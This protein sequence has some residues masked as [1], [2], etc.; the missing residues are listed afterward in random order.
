MT[1]PSVDPLE[2]REWFER[3]N[4][5]CLAEDPP[6]RVPTVDPP[7]IDVDDGDATD[8]HD[9]ASSIVT[10]LRD[11]LDSSNQATFESAG[12][13]A[14][15]EALPREHRALRDEAFWTWFACVP[16]RELVLARYPAPEPGA[17][18]KNGN[19]KS[20]LRD[21][22]NFL[23]K[24]ARETLPFRLWIRAE[25]SFDPSVRDPYAA[26][27]LGMID[28]WRSHVF[29]PL[30]AHHRPFLRA[31]IAFQFP[32][33]GDGPALNTAQVREMAKELSQSCATVSVEALDEAQCSAM[34]A[35]VHRE[36]I[37]GRV[38]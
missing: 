14:I 28:F 31:W 4:R 38:E 17:K 29:R 9:L 12:A 13:V 10:K 15:H 5:D 24:G 33:T 32:G 6:A 35:R 30:F 2:A 1:Y 11:L 26:S 37:E 3:W 22:A 20:P 25:M 18:D 16:A 27:R 19:Y 23:G 8:W 7:V 36:R 21:R 34:I